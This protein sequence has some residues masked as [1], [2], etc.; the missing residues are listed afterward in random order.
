MNQY[1]TVSL[2][3]VKDNFK[4][5]LVLPVGASWDLTDAVMQELVSSLAE[6]KKIDQERA[7]TKE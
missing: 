4:F 5:Q 3:I 7:N 2:E 1:L 6:M